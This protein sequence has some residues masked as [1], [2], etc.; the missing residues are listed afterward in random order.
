LIGKIISSIG[1]NEDIDMNKLN[2]AMKTRI[3]NLERQLA[4]RHLY[5]IDT[6]E[7]KEILL[8]GNNKYRSFLLNKR[9]RNIPA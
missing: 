7:I 8:L 5:N 1:L 4:E 2:E 9:L 6:Q 3:I